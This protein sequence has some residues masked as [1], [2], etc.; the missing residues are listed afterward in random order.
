MVSA[1]VTKPSG[2]A[3]GDLVFVIVPYSTSTAVR[4]TMSTSG[5]ASWNRD[6][7]VDTLAYGAALLWKILNATDV[8][9][10]WN[11]ADATNYYV[12]AVAYSQN[13]PPIVSA[14]LKQAVGSGTTAQ[15]T[16]NFSAISK[17]AGSRSII[18]LGIDRDATVT[19]SPPAGWSLDI[20]S[21]DSVFD[22]FATN[23][24]S[25]TYTGTSISIGGMF[26]SPGYPECGWAF[27]II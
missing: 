25:S 15:T 17:S 21:T 13:G 12:L 1:T 27:E 22:K 24:P 14:T 4:A 19:P 16:M 18:I 11:I 6:V 23:I 9:N 2:V 7:S 10:A 8:S 26:A 3:V 5:G 20:N